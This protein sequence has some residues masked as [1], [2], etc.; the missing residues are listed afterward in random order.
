M[1]LAQKIK[2]ED[3]Q[4]ILSGNLGELALERDEWAEA[5][6][7]FERQLPL[8]QEVGSVDLIAQAQYGPARVHEAEG[9]ADLALPLAQ[10]ALKIYE[11]LQHRYLAEVW[12]LVE[13]LKAEG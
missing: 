8:A 5:L 4:A 12:E 11:Q 1:R 2:N 6:S 9:R 13:R 3:I 7:W 10:D